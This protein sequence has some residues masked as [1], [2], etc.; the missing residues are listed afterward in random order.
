MLKFFKPNATNGALRATAEHFHF[1]GKLKP[2]IRHPEKPLALFSLRCLVCNPEKLVRVVAILLPGRKFLSRTRRPRDI[3]S[4]RQRSFELSQKKAP[5]KRSQFESE[6][7]SITSAAD[8]WAGSG[9][10]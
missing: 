3:M 6:V 5:P 1:G 2:G 9:R 10:G 8:R 7:A 4:V